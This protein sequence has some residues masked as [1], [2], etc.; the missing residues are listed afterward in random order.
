MNLTLGYVSI[1]KR[2]SLTRWKTGDLRESKPWTQNC[3]IVVTPNIIIIIVTII[4]NSINCKIVKE[5]KTII[6]YEVRVK[7]I[8]DRVGILISKDVIWDQRE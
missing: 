6:L 1:N 4:N 5:C 2:T 8:K 3:M 7:F